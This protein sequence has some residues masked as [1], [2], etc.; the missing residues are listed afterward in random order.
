MSDDHNNNEDL[1][2]VADSIEP[3]A[4]ASGPGN[5]FGP[6]TFDIEND[7]AD[8]L[9]ELRS[10]SDDNDEKEELFSQA[11]QLLSAMPE[12][13]RRR[14]VK[15]LAEVV[16]MHE[17]EVNACIKRA[18]QTPLSHGQM[19]D[20]IIPH[21]GDVIGCF[22]K[23]FRYNDAA[24]VWE[25]LEQQALEQYPRKLFEGQQL[26]KRQ[27]DYRQIM[28][29]VHSSVVNDDFFSGAPNGITTPKGF[30]CVEG[31]AVVLKAH[32]R[33][34]RAVHS[35]A[36]NPDNAKPRLLLSALRRAFGEYHADDQIRQLQMFA[37][38]AL[39]GLQ[40]KVQMAVLLHGA[41]A[42]FKSSFLQVLQALVHKAS[43]CS[44]SPLDLDQEYQRASLAGKLLNLA[45]ELDRDKPIPAA[46]FKSVL[47][48]DLISARNP[49][50][51]PFNFSADCGNWFCGN[52]FPTTRDQSDG[53]WRRWAIVH[54]VHGVPQQE[55]NPNLVAQICKNELG[56]V[57]GWCIAGVNDYLEN[58]LLLSP[59]HYEQLEHWRNE[60]NSVAS[61]ILDT[62]SQVEAVEPGKA[63]LPTSEAYTLYKDW[64]R[65]AG[66]QPLGKGLFR[67]Y[68][69]ERGHA[70]LENKTGHRFDGLA[71]KSKFGV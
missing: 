25:P 49:Y 42:S 69:V 2:N 31:G 47:G 11:L 13:R 58:G 30:L 55:R 40:H 12:L 65:T 56:A 24:H 23:L 15:D 35:V 3:T 7:W 19:A 71:I 64:C 5:F 48:G 70:V 66:R 46:G 43:V 1:L 50:G 53:F 22:G 52:F 63:S 44:V 54:F 68:L 17:R 14:A 4:Q 26:C 62:D 28:H 32:S 41:G 37:G 45:P 34:H 21:I 16:R 33:E 8:V 59:A 6:L 57:L 51:M 10:T 60:S 36:V 18:T 38:L 20:R 9:E 29:C 67:A 27:S 39:F 61:W